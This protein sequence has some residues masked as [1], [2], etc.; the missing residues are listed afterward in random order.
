MSILNHYKRNLFVWSCIVVFVVL[1]GVFTSINNASAIGYGG[2]GGRPAYPRD[3]NPRTESIFIHTLEPGSFQNEG[4]LVLNNTG[5]EKTLLVYAVD[6][7]V[8][9]GGVF[10]CQQLSASKTGVGAWIN[11]AKFELKLDSG[12]SEIVPFTITVPENASVGEQNGCIV[13]QEKKEIEEGQAGVTISFR[14]GLRVLITIPGEII[15]KLEIVD[16]NTKHL[17]DGSYLLQ[18]SV[19]NLGNVSIDADIQIIT[20][21]FGLDYIQHG[22]KF[23]VL[24][25]EISDWNFELKKPFWGG[26]YQSGFIVKYE[27]GQEVEIGKESGEQEVIL[28]GPS[29]WFFSTPKPLALAIEIIILLSII[30][31]GLLFWLSIK[32]KK[33]INENW[34]EYKIKIGEDIKTIAERFDVSWKLLVKTN[35]LQ[36]PYVLKKGQKI[37]TPPIKK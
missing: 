23:P 1:I 36:P 29:V 2:I 5:E 16:F 8:S 20:R 30:S 24:R 31:S 37:K 34:I 32:R 14:T 22:G 11:L 18:P 6:S 12:G 33:W 15:R 27:E 7:V 19:K 35:K 13:I 4:V 10:A 17:D 26:W 21:F 25:G 28:E 9:S 3:D